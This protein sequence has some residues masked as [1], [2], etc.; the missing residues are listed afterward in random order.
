MGSKIQVSL[1][2]T[3][4]RNILLAVMATNQYV[5]MISLVSLLIHT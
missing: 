4:I 5:L 2:Q 1:I 3:N